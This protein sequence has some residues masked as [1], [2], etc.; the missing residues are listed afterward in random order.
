MN[1]IILKGRLTRNVEMSYGNDS[2]HTA[3][4]R[5]NI[6][7]DDRTWKQEDGK[8]H[9]DYIPCFAVG[10]TAEIAEMNLCKGK[11][12]LLYGKMQS[13]KYTNKD[14][15]VV[16]TLQMKV[17]EIEFCGKKADSP[18]PYDDSFMNIPDIGEDDL[19]FK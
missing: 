6:A 7:V 19:P 16:Y 11:E 18:M 12:V 2:N 5:W 3:F 10:K 15:K 17:E 1:K 9:T 4:A 14:K 8:Y 13:G